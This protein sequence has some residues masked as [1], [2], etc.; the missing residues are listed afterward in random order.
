MNS[1]TTCC[2][3]RTSLLEKMKMTTTWY[4]RTAEVKAKVKEVER[5]GTEG[6][7]E[8][9]RDGG[10]RCHLREFHQERKDKESYERLFKIVYLSSMHVKL[11]LLLDEESLSN[12]E[13]CICSTSLLGS[14]NSDLWTPSGCS[15]GVLPSDNLAKYPV[16]L[17]LYPCLRPWCW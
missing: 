15:C 14:A 1:R 5:G 6:N 4:Q 12:F 9:E 3:R 8:G 11:H 7:G 10:G 13:T 2:R 16:L 17:P